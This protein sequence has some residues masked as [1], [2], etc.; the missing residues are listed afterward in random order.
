MKNNNKRDMVCRCMLLRHENS[1][2]VVRY[3]DGEMSAVLFGGEKYSEYD[4]DFWTTLRNQIGLERSL[5]IDFCIVSDIGGFDKPDDMDNPSC[6]VDESVW[7]RSTITKAIDLLELSIN[8]EVLTNEG[9]RI[10]GINGSLS[11]D[12]IAFTARFL[13]EIHYNDPDIKSMDIDEVSSEED[14]AEETAKCVPTESAEFAQTAPPRVAENGE[15]S[16]L[17]KHFYRMMEEDERAGAR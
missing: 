17:A 10:C 7:K 6:S 16:E 15:S 5:T 12:G 9:Q 8:A 1:V 11:G 4:E 13:R 3:R 14:T 2:Y